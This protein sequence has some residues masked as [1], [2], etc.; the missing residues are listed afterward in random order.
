VAAPEAVAN[1][2]RVTRLVALALAVTVFGGAC[3]APPP[4]APR[5]VV[6]GLVSEPV[7]IMADDP[8]ARVIR[9]AVTETLVRRDGAGRF[10]ARLAERV[11]TME[12]GDLA[13][14]G[15]ETAH[16]EQ[17]VA[18]FT[19][20][21][22]ARWQDGTP[23]T[24][25]DVKFAFDDDR[26]APPASERRWIA[27]RVASVDV[28]D[29]R[30]VRFT[31][32]A[33]ERWPLYPLAASVLPA[34]LLRGASAEQ[35]AAYDRMP[36]HAGPF[37]VA[38]W[39]AGVGMTLRPFAR[40]VGGAPQ[41]DRIEVRFY[42]DERALVDALRRGDVEVAPSPA[43]EADVTRTL[44]RF[45]GPDAT[46]RAQYKPAMS[47]EMLRFGAHGAVADHAVRA[48]LLLAIDRRRLVDDLFA[49]RALVPRSFLVPPLDVASAPMAA[50]RYDTTA[51]TAMLDAAGFVRGQFG[52]LERGSDR[53]ALTLLVADGSEA[54]AAAARSVTADL[55]VVG[56]AVSV[57][58]RSRDE[59]AATVAEGDFDLALLA[60]PADDPMRAA[61]LYAGIDPWFDVLREAAAD[62]V[63]PARSDLFAELQRVWAEAV[64]GV[65]LYQELKVDVAPA[66]LEGIEPTPDGGPITWNAGLWRFSG[67]VN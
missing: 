67:Q 19:L 54:R 53:L 41:L 34:H 61:A 28:I 18:T 62:A 65:P 10:V 47:V 38:G 49:G 42:R 44:D 21:D 2:F 55:A 46:L 56:V 4:S 15:D 39:I 23:V 32:D 60:Q 64:P 27:D 48:A 37:R 66:R 3:A 20:R 24:S 52:I 12:N 26:R 6:M 22:D 35:R 63:G 58:Q 57:V 31:Y 33:G 13:I 16:E 36:V 7:S 43:I 45:A 8:V 29:E 50:P 30:R 40:Y 9:S 59:L 25:A 5:D 1:P 11:P 17:L 14:V 51:A